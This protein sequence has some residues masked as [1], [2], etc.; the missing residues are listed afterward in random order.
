M[1]CLKQWW[2]EHQPGPNEPPFDEIV[3]KIK[4]VTDRLGNE[5]VFTMTV[6][7][8]GKREP[9]FLAEVTGVV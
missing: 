2:S 9:L 7:E 6:D 3:Q 4:T 8:N 1:K 5:I